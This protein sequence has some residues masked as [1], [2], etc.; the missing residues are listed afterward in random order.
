MGEKREALRSGQPRWLLKAGLRQGGRYLE[1][2]EF[3]NRSFADPGLV[4]ASEVP[5]NF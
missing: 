3:L 5:S 4:E 2:R 1:V